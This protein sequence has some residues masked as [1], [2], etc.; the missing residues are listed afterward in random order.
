MF[1]QLD[2]VQ[3]DAVLFLDNGQPP[4]NAAIGFSTVLSLPFALDEL[5]PQIAAAVDG[6]TETTE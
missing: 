6:E 4:L 1:E 2:V 3:R 5:V